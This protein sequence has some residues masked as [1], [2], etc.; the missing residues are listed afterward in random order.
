[1]VKG[2]KEGVGLVTSARVTEEVDCQAQ[3]QSGMKPT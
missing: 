3:K 2:G 1:M